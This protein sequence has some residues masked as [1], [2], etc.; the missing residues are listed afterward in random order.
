M[1]KKTNTNINGT[2]YFRVTATVGR[3]PNGSL[4]RKQFYGESKKEAEAKRDEYMTSIKQGLSASFDKLT[5]ND[6][7]HQWFESVHKPTLAL[8]SVHRYNVD[9]R[10]I[11]GSALSSMKL[12][13][14]KA[15]H[16]Q[17]HY[18][19]LLESGASV[20]MVKNVGKLLSPFFSYAVKSDLILKNPMFAVVP[21]RERKIEA[22]KRI[23][24][25]DDIQKIVSHTKHNG[26]AFIFVFLL[27]S[28][29]RQGEALALAHGDINMDSGIIRVNKSVNHLTVDGKYQA[30]VSTTKTTGSSREIPLLCDLR[31]ML[32]E[33][34]TA[35]KEKH[36]KLG[37][38]F[39]GNSI[40]F[41]SETGRYIEGKNLRIR[42]KRLLN[43]LK[44]EPIAVH[45]LRHTFCSVLAENGVN[46]KTASELM[47]H[48]DVNTTMRIYTHVQKEEKR[49]GIDTLS[50]LFAY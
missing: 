19:E 37:I 21:P 4:I 32:V 42:F 45:S 30:V 14:V 44:I 41:S 11:L 24:S 36:Q 17:R 13:D 38:P 15:L 27:F 18:N 16:I 40:L 23:L 3:N 33:H 46:L 34:M 1:A 10:R 29:L 47:G 9:N 5:L 25:K 50:G 20:N 49:R 8:S 28:G 7:Y 26:S 12:I 6:A 22:N 2:N 31:S 35:E 43:R 48:S 39:D